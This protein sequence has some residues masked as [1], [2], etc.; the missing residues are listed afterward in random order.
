MSRVIK[1]ALASYGMSGRIFH[2]PFLDSHPGFDL[3][4]ILERSKNESRQRYPH[5]RIAREYTEILNDP[6]VDL[7]VVN[8]PN[9]LHFSMAKAALLAGKHVVVEK[10]FTTTV[11]EGRELI[12]VARESKRM[13]SVYHNRRLQSGFKTVQKLLAD[14]LLGRLNT[15]EITIDRY[16]PQPG[17]KKWKEE[18]N[19]GAGLLYDL[20]SHLLDEAL[21][22]FGT[23]QSLCA[24]LRIEREAGQ[25]C[26]YFNIRLNYAHGGNNFKVI[27][28]ASMLAR[29]PAPAYVLHGTEGSWVKH[30]PDRQEER[31]DAGVLPVEPGPTGEC[32][33]EDESDWGILHTDSGRHRFPSIAGSYQ[34]YYD[35]IY[36]HL[37]EGEGALAVSPEQALRVVE[38]IEQVEHS[39]HEQA[40]IAI[41]LE[42][43]ET[44]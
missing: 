43:G 19:P 32:T 24:D 6:T 38:L 26:D 20:G 15:C 42:I 35:N 40:C 31:L 9:P 28:K 10:P 25:V 27:L 11:A 36:R 5:C 39:A 1:V 7:V 18:K 41:N 22:H 34:D 12:S 16:R 21:M 2:A 13:L 44:G 14:Q 4:L 8:T 23:P 3:S 33:E 30:A 29:E 37:I 17:P